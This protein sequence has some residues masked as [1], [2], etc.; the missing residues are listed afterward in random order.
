MSQ[1]T[2]PKPTYMTVCDL[3]DEEIDDER[4]NP[5]E[6]ASL[7]ATAPAGSLGHGY[8]PHAEVPKQRRVWL[9]W[10]P[11]G[12]DRLMPWQEKK[13]PRNAP[14]RYDFHAQCI[15]D[16]VELAVAHRENADAA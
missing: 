14:R 13:H 15:L 2:R 9:L 7:T 12:R 5:G 1:T 16:L 6:A 11:A 8:G 10:P 3:C 4:R